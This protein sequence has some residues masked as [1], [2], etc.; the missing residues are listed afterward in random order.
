MTNS[1]AMALEE[2]W[3]G[4]E[5]VFSPNP[6]DLENLFGRQNHR[7]LEIGFGNGESLAAQANESPDS[8]YLGIEVHRPGIG[9]LLIRIKQL[10][11]KNIRISGHDAMDVLVHQLPSD[12]FDTIQLFFPDP[13]PKKKHHKRRIVQDA[14]VELTHRVL[15]HKGLFHVATDWH[16]YVEHVVKVM[17]RHQNNFKDVSLPGLAKPKHRPVTKFETRGIKKGHGVW[18]LIYRK[19]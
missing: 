14:F 7:I 9:H 17:H 19:R 1:Q 12:S 3:S 6:C 18:D 15:R 11:L 5:L 2:D 4:M 13:W 8:D 16:P 10:S